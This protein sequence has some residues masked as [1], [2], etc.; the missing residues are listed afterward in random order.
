MTGGLVASGAVGLF[1]QYRE[2]VE[3]LANY[4]QEMAKGAALK[5]HQFVRDIEKTTKLVTQTPEIIKTGLSKAY[6]FELIKFLK[7]IPAVSEAALVGLDGREQMKLSRTE[8]VLREDFRERSSDEAFVR[9]R[10]GDSYY[11]PVYFVRNSEPYM[12]MAVPIGRFAGE[13]VGVL[14]AEVNLKYIWDVVSEIQVGRAGYAYVVS[15]KGDLIAHPDISLVLEKRNLT[16]LPQVKAALA[17][18]Q[19]SI[20]GQPSLVGQRVFASHASIP[21][22]GW[23]VF[24]ERPVAEAYAPLYASILRTSLLVFLG[25]GIAVAVSLL[26]NRRV[27]RPVEV[28]RDGVARIGRGD[29]EHRLQIDT[30]DEIESLAEEFNR[31][32]DRLQGS[33]A[34]LE[35]KVE[36]RTREL[37]I[38]NSRLSEE[39]RHKSA[40]LANMSHEFRTPLN[41]IIG[42]SE[43]LLDPALKVTEEE[44]KQFL[45][46]ILNSG[47]HL[48]KLI[49]EILDLSKIEAGRME[50]EIE[51]AS[52]RDLFEM[53]QS[54]TRAL[55]ARKRIEC[56]FDA[57][58]LRE[59]IAMDAARIKQ[60]LLNL[61][62]NA[63]KFTP[64]GG[65]VWVEARVENEMVRVEM[66][67]TG[68]GI[69]AEEQDRIFLEFHQIKV[70]KDGGKPEGTGLGLALARRFVEMHGG[71]LW[72]E[73]QV[74]KGSRFIFTLPI[75]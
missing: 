65:R 55:A 59:P 26:L 12:T 33:Y 37:A 71:R 24:V 66:G 64:E 22:L 13:I 3:A 54:S 48:L 32:A 69:P 7:S 5:I 1:F 45:T 60:V 34:E 61:V 41:A 63:F 39:S 57:D 27:V 70:A 40:F 9:A 29:L 50:L 2:N 25:L 10:A 74:G 14:I 23:V 68:P 75:R 15:H 46:D 16:A 8:M 62:G 42:F 56:R 21:D 73:S 17:G 31:M 35:R 72:V 38:V 44:R 52:L 11:G 53:V 36:A 30:G 18:G 58:G 4:Q 6:E 19:T 20:G 43:V 49:N 47:R 51:P 28:L 67:D